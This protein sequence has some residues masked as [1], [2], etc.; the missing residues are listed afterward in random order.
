MG[1]LYTEHGE[2]VTTGLFTYAVLSPINGFVGGGL[3]SRMGGVTWIKQMITGAFL[4]PFLVSS[5]ALIV[6]FVA[7][8]YHASRAI[9][10]KSPTLH[11]Y[12]I[13]Y[14]SLYKLHF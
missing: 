8:S 2:M 9:P 11:L 14:I 5:T 1:H 13:D 3:Y 6:N 4:L 12:N 7:I 10:C